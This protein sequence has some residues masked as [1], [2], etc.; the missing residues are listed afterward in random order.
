MVNEFVNIDYIRREYGFS[1]TQCGMEKC[2]PSHSYGPAIRDHFL[3]HYVLE[4]KGSF[5]IDGK[6][7][8]ISKGSGFLIPPNVITYYIADKEDPWTYVWVG[9]KGI[10]VE[11]FLKSVGLTRNNPLF[12]NSNSGFME[13]CLENMIEASKLK[14][15]SELRL[16]GYLNIFLS[17]FLEN[18][19]KDMVSNS[20]YKDFYIEKALLYISNNFSRELSIGNISS[21]IG[22]NKNYFSSLFKDKVGESPKEYIIKY[23][24]DKAVSLLKEDKLTI[25]QI[26]RSV[27]YN[28]PLGFSKIFKKIKGASPKLYKKKDEKREL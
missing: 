2:N 24:M 1:F 17:E 23:R 13:E 25:S 11:D 22:L 6:T 8:S 3:I 9:F 5:S 10:N 18:A 14:F 28:D 7:Y 21:H 15:G 16:N 27:G 19:K 4:G 20:D 12:F 26:S